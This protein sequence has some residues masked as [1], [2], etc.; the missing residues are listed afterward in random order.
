MAG[1]VQGAAVFLDRD[2]T[3]IRDVGYLRRADQI[4]ILPQVPA[5]L[6]LL[7]EHGFRLVLVTNQ[8]AVGRGWMTEKDLA[9]IHSTL[10]AQLAQQDATLDAIYYCPHH[11]VEG[12]GVYRLAC[13]CRKPNVG[14]V[15]R[16]VAEFG[17]NPANSYVIGDQKTDIELAE[18]IGATALLICQDESTAAFPRAGSI[19]VPDLWQAAQWILRRMVRSAQAQE[20]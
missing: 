20:R 12:T 5:A 17:L 1:S 4:E 2:G 9:E 15:E 6:R 3:L 16:A 13:R 7:R 11:P 19:P 10:A 14:M 8:S 18:R